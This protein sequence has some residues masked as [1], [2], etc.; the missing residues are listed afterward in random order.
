MIGYD[1]M[2][3]YILKYESLKK[4]LKQFKEDLL[5]ECKKCN[6]HLYQCKDCSIHAIVNRITDDL[7]E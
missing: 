1:W 5:K 7:E 2:M 4:Q 3:E 6:K